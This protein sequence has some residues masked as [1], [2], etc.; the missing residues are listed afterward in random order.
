M[1]PAIQKNAVLK[2]TA[3]AK[4]ARLTMLFCPQSNASGD[5]NSDERFANASAGSYIDTRELSKIGDSVLKPHKK[6]KLVSPNTRIITRAGP[7]TLANP[8]CTLTGLSSHPGNLGEW[9]G[10]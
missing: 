6:C 2:T 4:R 8:K 1:N 5:T 10:F 3:A 7:E 9:R